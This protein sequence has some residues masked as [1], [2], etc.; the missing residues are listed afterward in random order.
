MNDAPPIPDGCR[1]DGY[2]LT[3][4]GAIRIRA[5]KDNDLE[6]KT[7]V[8]RGAFYIPINAIMYAIWRRD[9]PDA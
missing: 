7:N 5:D 4:Y 1:W 3:L 8:D 2:W 6:I 9:N